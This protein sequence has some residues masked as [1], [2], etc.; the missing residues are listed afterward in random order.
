MNGQLISTAISDRSVMLHTTGQEDAISHVF[1]NASHISRCE[2][3]SAVLKSAVMLS[4]TEHSLL[5]GSR[6]CFQ[7][8]SHS[9]YTSAY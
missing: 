9:H 8:G 6:E 5:L 4:E 1:T 7:S 3:P 2:I